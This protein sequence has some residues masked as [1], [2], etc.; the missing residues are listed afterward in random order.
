M[1]L[2]LSAKM[3]RNVE[4]KQDLEVTVTMTIQVSKILANKSVNN[5]YTVS[6]WILCVYKKKYISKP[7]Q[8]VFFHNC[9]VACSLSAKGGQRLAT[10][11]LVIIGCYNR[12]V[13]KF[14]ILKV[15]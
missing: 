12:F 1:P 3:N 5:I 2:G 10:T 9:G 7:S 13:Q 15:F 14:K 6:S 4:V 8:Q 11:A